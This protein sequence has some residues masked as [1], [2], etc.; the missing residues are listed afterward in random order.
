M[1][2]KEL[3]INEKRLLYLILIVSLLTFLLILQNINGLF[4]S[5]LD[6][7]VNLSMQKMQT[8]FLIEISKIIN[9]TFEPGVFVVY[10]LIVIGILFYKKRIMEATGLAIFTLISAGLLDLIKILVQRPRP[11]DSLIIETDP[12]F[13]S[14]HALMAVVFFGTL[15]YLFEHHVKSVRTKIWLTVLSVLIVIIIG[16]SRI[17]LNIH[18]FSDVLA[19]YAL[20]T[21]LLISF[22][23]IVHKV[24]LFRNRGY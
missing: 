9:Y 5:S 7:N 1:I 3:E 4:F 20:G 2:K 23:L 18:W 16:A 19:S 21:F 6:S 8:P 15:I 11:F 10:F 24:H 12:S 22:V 13:P 14:G 17:Y